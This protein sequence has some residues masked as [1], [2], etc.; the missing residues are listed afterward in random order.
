[1]DPKFA[2]RPIAVASSYY[3]GGRMD[4]EQMPET[5]NRGARHRRAQS[6]TFF[7]L[8]DEDILLDDV[9]ADFNFANI[10][11]PSLSSDAPIPTTTG[12]S[13]SKS[14]GESSDVNAAKSTASRPL[15]T[16][17]H[18]RS[19]SV[20]ADFFD[21][22]GLNSAAESEKFSGGGYRHR[23]SNS[24]DGSAA[25]SFEGDSMSMML[26]NSKKA[27]APDKL[28][29]LALID[30]KRAKRILA[31]RQ[32]AARSKERKIRYT[33]ELERKVQTL[34]N[35]ATTLS[36]QVTMLQRDTS[37][38]TSENKELKLRLQAMEQQA[39]LRDA[40]NETLRAEVQRLKI[41]TGQ[42]LP[43]NGMNYKRS[44]PSPQYS[45][46]PQT[47]HHFGN[48]NT[49]QQQQQQQIRTPNNHQPKPTF[50]DFN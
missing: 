7:R 25:S 24:M 10:D 14:E 12:D 42:M 21:G 6:E 4:I 13:S 1:M 29:E 15:S 22:L 17:S 23:H 8:P 16:S 30:P 9:V 35:E 37:G 47:F 32:S 45:S 2:G 20:D 48:Q 50:M 27:L 26:D 5:P 38:L 34:Q 41:E 49:Q 31:N 43:L 40:L 39:K 19:L 18:I 33:G 44:L 36:T 11:L 3:G 28:A 46:H